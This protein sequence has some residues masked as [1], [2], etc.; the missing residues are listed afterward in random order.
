MTKT[1]YW[2]IVD[3]LKLIK[4]AKGNSSRETITKS[5]INHLSTNVNLMREAQ[6]FAE[7]EIIDKIEKC[8]IYEEVTKQMD[9]DGASPVISKEELISLLSSKEKSQ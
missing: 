2:K 1:E 5:Y 7:K 3:T 8:K 9:R 6:S 4:I